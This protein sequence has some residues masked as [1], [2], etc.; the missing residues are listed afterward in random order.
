MTDKLD[1]S[2]GVLSSYRVI[3]FSRLAPGPMTTMVLG[4]L[5]ADVI[6]VEEPGGGRRARDERVLQGQPR[7]DYS[8]EEWRWR[9]FNPLERNKRSIAVDLRS[10]S[11]RD[12]ALRLLSTADVAVEGFRPGVM[13]R[14]G[15]D[16]QAV[17]R[18]NRKIVY[19]SIT[20]YGQV[21]SRTPLVGHDLNYLAYAG[22]LSL[23]GGTDGSPVV[24]INV[25]ADYASG[26]LRAVSA[27]LGALLSRERS[28]DGQWI[29][30]A[31]ADG[32]VGLLAVE[33]AR[34]LSSGL[35]PKAGETYLTGGT[36][37]YNVY[38]TREHR[39]IT[40]A[41]NEPHFYRRLCE[42]LDLSDLADRQFGDADEQRQAREILA[43]RFRTRTLPEWC[44]ALA[45]QQIP[46]A[47]VRRI[48]EVVN[49][50][51]FRERGLF[52]TVEHPELGNVVQVSSVVP[53]SGRHDF[54]PR[55]PSR[56]GAD[57]HSVLSELGYHDSEIDD[58]IEREIVV[59]PAVGD[60]T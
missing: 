54:V 36:A 26:S 20:G 4:D 33:V 3:D 7:D 51:C 49:D 34:Y 39:W 59:A 15:L 45:A 17:R 44:D 18:V 27:I 40:I 8:A 9:S 16:Y 37:Y 22:A 1:D 21:G 12:L 23:I 42:F 56:P 53:I 24:P 28:G 38:E 14:L 43:E 11:G 6:K 52:V 5:G 57:F 46:F 2:T 29:D 60:W 25:I 19:C 10:D 41:C 50:E 30:V 13:Q 55:N 48:D 58:F 47:P 35:V 32:V 31:M